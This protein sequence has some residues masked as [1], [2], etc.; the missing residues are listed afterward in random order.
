MSESSITAIVPAAGIGSRMQS[1]IPK[2]Y[3]PIHRQAMLEITINRLLSVKHIDTL[4]VALHPEDLWFEQLEVASHDRIQ[5]VIGGDSRA[6]SVINALKL[7]DKS[8]WALVHDAARPCVRK[9]DVE[10]LI[11]H[12][13][14]MLSGGGILAVKV[15]D[16]I[17]QSS[18]AQPLLINNTVDRSGLWHALTP[19]MF[20][21]GE[22][23]KAY[24]S[25]LSEG[26]TLTD[27][28]SAIEHDGLPVQLFESSKE[29]IKV[30]HPEDIALASFYLSKD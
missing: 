5:T 30:T 25:A 20:K 7:C 4:I 14:T 16:T 17:K 2:Q 1:A 19:Q 22:L 26:Y 24:Q 11:Y 21:V 9:E 27:E 12:C 29:N 6:E 15:V 3:L 18:I 28:A 10:T 13:H 8:H 23:L